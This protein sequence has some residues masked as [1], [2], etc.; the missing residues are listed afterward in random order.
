MGCAGAA[1]VRRGTRTTRCH[2][3][4]EPTGSSSRA[5]ARSVRHRRPSS[6]HR[7]RPASR[8]RAAGRGRPPPPPPPP[9][10]A[11]PPPPARGSPP[12]PPAAPAPPAAA[13]GARLPHAAFEY[14]PFLPSPSRPPD[15]AEDDVVEMGVDP[16]RIVLLG[17]G[18]RFRIVRHLAGLRQ[19]LDVVDVRGLV[20]DQHERVQES[21]GGGV[22]EGD[23]RADPRGLRHRPEDAAKCAPARASRARTVHVIGRSHARRP[24]SESAIAAAPAIR[25]RAAANQKLHPPASAPFSTPA[26]WAMVGS[27]DHASLFPGR[28][29]TIEMAAYSGF[30]LTSVEVGWPV[31]SPWKRTMPRP[32]SRTQILA[33]R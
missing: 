24:R 3:R 25:T 12:P 28:K 14:P 15:V 23:G 21:P 20:R 32:S 1:R 10:G 31:A 4:T 16:D 6:R 29:K 9:P 27:S 30:P 5:A 18:A 2:R 33:W 17:G 11:P 22:E 8:S 19:L 26:R 7:G 13:D